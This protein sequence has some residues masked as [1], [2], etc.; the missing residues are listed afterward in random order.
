M[1]EWVGYIALALLIG[2]FSFLAIE[3]QELLKW[4]TSVEARLR[5]LFHLVG[6]DGKHK[7]HDRD[8]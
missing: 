2:G 8:R 3:H 4:K 1:G 6:H 5:K 7:T